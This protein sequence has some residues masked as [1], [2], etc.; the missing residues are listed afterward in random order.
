[1]GDRSRLGRGVNEETIDYEGVMRRATGH[2]SVTIE[3]LYQRSRGLWEG[4]LQTKRRRS[5]LVL[6][7]RVA[8]GN[9][10]TMNPLG[11]RV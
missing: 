1:M 8:V 10:L 6:G 4:E 9:A 11:P 7:A 3:P 2:E 5:V